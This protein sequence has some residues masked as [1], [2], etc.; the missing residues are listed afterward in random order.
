M[1]PGAIDSQLLIGY[2]LISLGLPSR[3]SSDSD[4]SSRGGSIWPA[5]PINQYSNNS[6]PGII[7]RFQ[8]KDVNRSDS[9]GKDQIAM[10]DR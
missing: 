9:R 10:D 7:D 8:G 4:Y 5:Q 1:G 2:F 6:S 3:N